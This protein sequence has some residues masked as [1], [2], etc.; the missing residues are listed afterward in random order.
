MASCC[1][2]YPPDDWGGLLAMQG[3][4]ARVGNYIDGRCPAAW[5]CY[6]E[7]VLDRQRRPWG[8]ELREIV[9]AVIIAPEASSAAMA[10]AEAV[11]RASI[12]L[13]ALDEAQLPLLSYDFRNAREPFQPLRRCDACS[14]SVQL[15]T[16]G[17]SS[18][19]SRD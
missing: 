19:C 2:A 18:A 14:T 16:L 10:Y 9:E 8:S 4:Q 3:H 1:A 12:A 17:S 15:Q 7:I 11:H 5:F 13:L 6:D